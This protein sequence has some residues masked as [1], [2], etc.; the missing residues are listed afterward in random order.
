[1]ENVFVFVSPLT[2]LTVLDNVWLIETLN[3]LDTDKVKPLTSIIN[4]S[5]VSRKDEILDGK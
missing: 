5:L 4:A 3:K 1:M 2:A